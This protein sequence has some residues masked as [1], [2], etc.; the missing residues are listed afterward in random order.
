MRLFFDIQSRGA[1]NDLDELSGDDRLSGAIERE[2]QLADHL[3]GVLARAVHGRH[4]SALLRSGVL[5]ET[6]VEQVDELELLEALQCLR[7]E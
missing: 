6:V 5:L 3:A 7:I 1:R 2:R 4:A